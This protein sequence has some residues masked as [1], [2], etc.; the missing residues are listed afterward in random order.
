[1]PSEARVCAQQ[2]LRRVF[3]QGAYAERAFH[4]LADRL[5]QRDRALAMHIAYGAIQRAGTLDHVIERLTSRAPS[6]LD[7]AVLAA[8]RTGLYE[9]IYLDNAAAH[10]VVDDAVELV[11][12][13]G[14]RGH[15]LVNATLRRAAREPADLLA[16]LN[17]RTAAAAAIMHSHPPWMAQMWWDQLGAGQAR[18]LMVA[19]NE[20]AET[21]VRVNTLLTEPAKA[22]ATLPVGR[23]MEQGLLGQPLPEALVLD[24]RFDLLGSRQW[25][26]GELI[27]QSRAAMLVSR[28]LAPQR[29]ERV[30]DLCAAPGGKSTHLA[31]LM[32]GEGEVVAVEREPGRVR[33]LRE[34]VARMR[35]ESVRVVEADAE[36]PFAELASA[37]ADPAGARSKLTD[38]RF[39]RVLLDAPCSGLGTLQARPDLRWRASPERIGQLVAVQ[40]RM[41]AVAAE[42]VRPGGTLVYSTCTI[43]RA[44]NE[45]QIQSFLQA[46]PDFTPELPMAIESPAAAA[47][48]GDPYLTTLPSRDRSAGFFI[49]RLRRH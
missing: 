21:A 13:S 44:E 47:A 46:H 32:D 4:A 31:A 3:E 28:V 26:A 18:A 38:A 7:G 27:A 43:S 9:L 41:L 24:G 10:A 17:D 39:D 5:D 8:L 11:K 34:T 15:G 42:A 30:L 48:A 2:T 37:C 45:Q 22:A 40:A 19:D 1:M 14:S 23:E 25:Q 29:G 16:G 12:R 36:R 35:T 49:A 20:P 6:K 33:Q